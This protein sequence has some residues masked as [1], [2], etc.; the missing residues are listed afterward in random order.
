MG[1]GI[2]GFRVDAIPHVFE[3]DDF[4]DEPI[5]QNSGTSDKESYF[6]LDHP[7]TKDDPRSYELIK[8]WRKVLDEWA[9]THNEDEKVCQIY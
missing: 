7:Y 3:R 5:L 2:D 4:P 6:Y 8:S 9:D 1:K